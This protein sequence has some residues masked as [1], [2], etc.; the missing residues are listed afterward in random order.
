MR[1]DR[2]KLD[3]L[4]PVGRV[5]VNVVEVEISPASR[6]FMS[7]FVKACAVFASL[8]GLYVLNEV[9]LT[10]AHQKAHGKMDAT[11][12]QLPFVVFLFCCI[13]VTVWILESENGKGNGASTAARPYFGSSGAEAG[14]QSLQ[15][16]TVHGITHK[17][18]R[19]CGE[20]QVNFAKAGKSRP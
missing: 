15:S 19:V 4:P 14:N 11:S 3:L 8:H 10:T 20:M 5:G 13:V 17:G 6:A 7:M 2:E 12:W 18:K 1:T 16:G 9:H